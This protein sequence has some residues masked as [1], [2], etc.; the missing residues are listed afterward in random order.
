MQRVLLFLLVSG[1]DFTFFSIFLLILSPS[2]IYNNNNNNN[3]NNDFFCANILEDQAQWHNL[4][5]FAAA[6][7]VAVLAS[8]LLFDLS[9]CVDR[10]G[11][12][13]VLGGRQAGAAVDVQRRAD[14]EHDQTHARHR[15][16]EL[17]ER[18]RRQTDLDQVHGR[19]QPAVE[20]GLSRRRGRG[21]LTLLFLA[22]TVCIFYVDIG[23]SIGADIRVSQ[24]LQAMFYV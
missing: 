10:E 2:S 1:G 6:V 5:A 11:P 16:Q 20:A 3:N 9:S 12:P 21:S 14:R 4:V 7:V 8:L 22:L 13:R 19:H 24:T 15:H 23:S 18:G 17:E